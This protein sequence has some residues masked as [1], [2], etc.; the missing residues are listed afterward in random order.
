MLYV[1]GFFLSGFWIKN[2]RL[3]FYLETAT[4]HF[5]AEFVKRLESLCLPVIVNLVELP[6]VFIYSLFNQFAGNMYIDVK[7]FTQFDDAF[8]FT[9]VIF[10]FPFSKNVGIFVL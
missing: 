2:S 8:L 10:F 4:C 1:S 7:V 3:N 6:P 9:Q 5:K